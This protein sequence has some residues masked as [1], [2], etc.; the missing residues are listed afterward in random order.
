MCPTNNF[1]FVIN[2]YP[3]E[4][5]QNGKFCFAKIVAKMHAFSKFL[6]HTVNQSSIEQSYKIVETVKSF[7]ILLKVS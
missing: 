3:I 4:K 7:S 2:D 1:F 5:V 6:K